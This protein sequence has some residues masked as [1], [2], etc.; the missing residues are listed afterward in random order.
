MKFITVDPHGF[1][2]NF[3]SHDGYISRADNLHIA[4]Q[5]AFNRWL[6]NFDRLYRSCRLVELSDGKFTVEIKSHARN[7]G[8]VIGT[9]IETHHVD[10]YGTA[11]MFTSE[12]LRQNANP[13]IA[14]LYAA[15]ERAA[16]SGCPSVRRSNRSGAVVFTTRFPRY[17]T[18]GEFWSNE[19]AHLAYDNLDLAREQMAAA[20]IQP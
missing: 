15:M 6:F 19:S 1:N 4:T 10:Y 14:S 8:A 20:G 5:L 16:E 9:E 7:S 12:F 2:G 17:R 11:D 18:N 3:F 13:E